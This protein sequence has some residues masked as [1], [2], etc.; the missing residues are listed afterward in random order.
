MDTSSASSSLRPSTLARFGIQAMVFAAVSYPVFVLALTV[1]DQLVALP[2][3][4]TVAFAIAFVV[5]EA[6]L[7]G[8]VSTLFDGDRVLT[9]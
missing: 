4:V 6:G 9:D 7:L 8:L 5:V 3:R 1:R 2:F